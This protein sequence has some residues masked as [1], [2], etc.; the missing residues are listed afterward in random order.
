M[1]ETLQTLL[2]VVAGITGPACGFLGWWVRQLYADLKSSHKRYEALLREAI[3]VFGALE[4]LEHRDSRA[5]SRPST[6]EA[7][8]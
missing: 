3:S 1:S 7:E 6:E 8:S 5:H 4:R 2:A